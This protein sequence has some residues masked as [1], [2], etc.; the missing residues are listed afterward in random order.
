M[1]RR[2]LIRLLLIGATVAAILLIGVEAFA[3]VGGGQTYGG[4]GGGGGGGGDGIPIDLIIWLI[5][6]HPKIGIPVAIV[7]GVVYLYKHYGGGS[8]KPGFGEGGG[9]VVFSPDVGRQVRRKGVSDLRSQDP[10]FSR[11]VFSEFVFS[12]FEL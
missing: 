10:G 9:S 12:S 7:V 1:S 2:Q 8:K 3:R 6:R 4:G 5:I 11:F